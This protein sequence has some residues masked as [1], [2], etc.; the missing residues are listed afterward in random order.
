MRN[1]LLLIR[2]HYAF[3]MFVILELI[4]FVIIFSN[5]SYQQTSYFNSS[6]AIAGKL[7]Q[8]KEKLVG[9]FNL[10]SVNENLMK[11]NALL[12]QRLGISVPNNP[13]KDTSYSVSHVGDSVSQTTHYHYIPAKVLN[14]TIDQKLNYLTLNVGSRHGVKKNF[15]VISDKG[16]VG[17]VANVSQ[18]YCIV[19]TILSER[20]TPSAMVP[21]GTVG[22][23]AWDGKNVE[24]VDLTGIPQSVKLKPLDTVYTSGYGIFP[25]KIMIGR[26]AKAENG[27]G[28]KIWLSTKFRNLHFVYVIK[29]ETNIARTRIE[30]S[31][32][33][34]LK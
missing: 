7:Y 1:L 34:A 8:R 13:L 29:D 4:C 33:A 18:D 10:K 21:D 22:K 12:R 5:N 26:A 9:F 15:A 16:I 20:F 11:E 3:F 32:Q 17:K 24:M 27:Y 28:Y 30:D 14:S 6:R 23:I 25:E 2:Q 19:L 31:L